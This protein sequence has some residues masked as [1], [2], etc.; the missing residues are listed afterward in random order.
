VTNPGG[1][2]GDSTIREHTLLRDAINYV[3]SLGQ[4][5]SGTSI[6]VNNDGVVDSLT[7]IVNG[8]PDGW[9]EILWPHQWT[10]Y[11][12]QVRISGKTVGEYSFHLDL[13]LNTS[14]LAH[15]MFHVL[16]APDLYHYTHDMLQP[17]G[18]RDVMDQD[19]YPPQHMGCYMKFKYGRWIS[20]IPELTTPGTYTLNPLTSSTNNCM[21]IASP[22]STTE[23]FVVE[24]R[25][26]TSSLFES[27]LPGTG[28]LVYR[29]NA[30]LRGNASGPPDEVYIYRPRGTPS[31]NGNWE[32]AAF[33][34]DVG[35]A[36]INDATN[37]SSF[38]T[39]GSA[40]GL[41][42]CNIGASGSTISF[43][44]CT[45]PWYSISGN[46]G[47]RDAALHYTD[48]NG[49]PRTIFADHWGGY[50]FTVPSSWSGSVTPSK[51]D[52]TFS[53]VRRSY[54]NLGAS[55]TVQ[56]YIAIASDPYEPDNT[57]EEA[58]VITGAS[59]GHSVIPAA[60]V[61]WIQFTLDTTSAVTL[62]TYGKTSS[63][64]ELW[65]YDSNQN[66]L[67]YDDDSG[68][69]HSYSSILLK[70][71]VDP[72]PPGDYYAKVAEFG[73]DD[74][75]PS[76]DIFLVTAPCQSPAT[77]TISKAGTGSGT[78][79]A[80]G[81]NCGTD[82]SEVYAYNT[83]VT[84]TASPTAGSSFA[85][86]SGNADCSD[87]VVTMTKD[88]S[89]T[90][91]FTYEGYRLFINKAGTGSGLVTATGINCGTDCT[92]AYADNTQV[93]LT[94]SPAAGSY[95]A[96][97]SG[98]AD[99]S[100]GV[101]IMNTDK[102]CTA[103]FEEQLISTNDI[104]EPDNSK[105]E[106]REID[107]GISQTHSIF[108]TKDLDWVTFTLTT[109]SAVT[110]ETTGPTFSDTRLWLYDSNQNLLK[111]SD[112]YGNGYYSYI[113]LSCGVDAPS[114]GTYYVVV[115]GS[116]DF[117]EVHSYN[118]SLDVET[119]P[120][121]RDT[122]GVFRPSNGLL[123]LK[124][125]NTSGFADAALNYGLPGDYPIVG[126]WDGN[127]TVTIGIYR[128]G[129]FYLKNSNTLGD[130]EIV[131]PFGQ[132]GDQPIAGDWDGDGV[133]TIGV[134]R[135][136]TGQFLLRNDNSEGPADKSFY[137]GNVGDVGIAGDW[138]G[139]GL[140][141]TGV[142]RPSNGIIFLKNK[143]EDG[144]ADAALN[145]GLPGDM[146]V[147]GDWDNDGI[148]TIGVYRQGQFMLRNSNTIGFAEVIFGLGNPG[149][150]PIAGNWDGLP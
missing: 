23:Y 37:P 62:Q 3:A 69:D 139:D 91:T 2:N 10:L 90:A 61:D 137:L 48:G 102:S 133:D 31:G 146:P 75:I 49:V 107:S 109:K 145:Y 129:S 94:A 122:T 98:N 76:Y 150:M 35:R 63:N 25:N 108:P 7:F 140:D 4:F 14:V 84:L 46:V 87:G 112:N 79:T 117:A 80:P 116:L 106:A 121:D 149:D 53:P 57:P 16:G 68:W 144:F 45:S 142:F 5:P 110:L 71:D 59:Y 97:W 70:C 26:K 135:P 50:T 123:Y 143:N 101:V 141:T 27:A 24:Y 17:L 114:P 83:W 73:N 39:N 30:T 89:C 67:R 147:T 43:D 65:L 130:A 33:S 56:D 32:I 66:E 58:T 19:S 118:L 47:V 119:C 54:T 55:Q 103:K 113:H 136:S 95:F 92:E 88:T 34:S 11:T 100:D 41:N 148:D 128:E 85:G 42:L 8:N 138:D 127:G 9:S 18:G 134:Y 13:S 86:W 82:C 12:Y 6:D 29:I 36:A 96:G 105:N 111:F 124:N 44:L 52:Y 81:I 20:N 38:L 93:T 74:E 1:Y 40:G 120:L 51:P 131:L 115:A 125:S 126:D 60:D 15:E 104:Y 28:L 64:T 99:C 77:L 132:S 22:Y 21:K 78:V 72:L